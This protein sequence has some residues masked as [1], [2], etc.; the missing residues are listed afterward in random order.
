MKLWNLISWLPLLPA[1]LFGLIL[2]GG[3]DSGKEV[4]DEVTGNRAVKQ[5]QKVKE[6]IGELTE[7]QAKRFEGIPEDETKE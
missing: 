2:T 4:V 3:C 6:D 7:Q 1:A 5:Y